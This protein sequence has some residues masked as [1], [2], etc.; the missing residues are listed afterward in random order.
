M[1]EL[2]RTAALGTAAGL[3]DLRLRRGNDSLPIRVSDMVM[4]VVE[5]NG[6]IFKREQGREEEERCGGLGWHRADVISGRGQPHIQ[7]TQQT[8]RA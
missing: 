7:G 5:E 8:Q 6:V 2:H 4:L 3:R 1:D